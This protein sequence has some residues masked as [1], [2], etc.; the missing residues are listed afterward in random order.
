MNTLVKSA[1]VARALWELLRYDLTLR[2]G[3]FR[4][5]HRSLARARVSRDSKRSGPEADLSEAM[6]NALSLY[7]KRALCLQRSVATARL[8]RRYG[9][10]AELVIGYRADPF[11]SHAWVEVEGRIV[12]DSPAYQQRL[13]V[14]ERL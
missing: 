11:F 1:L 6:R 4:R 5:V 10:R 3:G 8:F 2:A 12:N 7:W 13:H 9:I 14:L